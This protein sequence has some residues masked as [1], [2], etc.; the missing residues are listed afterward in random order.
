MNTKRNILPMLLVALLLFCLPM[1]SLAEDVPI[2]NVSIR[3]TPIKGQILLEKTG[4]MQTT[5]EQGYLK[6][7]VFEIRAA[8]DIIGQDGTPWYS[9]GELVATMTTSGEGVEKSPLLP[10]GKYTVK[11]VS[12]PSGYVLDLTTYTVE[13]QASDQETPIV[14]ATVSS[15]NHPAEILLQKTEADGKALS[16]AQ[17]VLL[18]ADGCETA[19]AVSDADGL[20]R[21]RF[22]PQGQYTI[23]ET[24]APDGY[25]LNRSA[26]SV[27]V[28]PNWTNAEEPIATMVNQQKKIQF[29]KV[30]TAGTPM[31]GILF[32]LINAETGAVAET[33][34]SD[35]NG[36]FAFT[37]FDYG[38]WT[39]HEAAAP[40]GYSRMADY[41]FQ[42]DDSWSGTAPVLL[43][44]IPDYYAFIKVDA[45]GKPLQGV[46]FAL[47]DADG[48]LLQTLES[49]EN[50]I[51]RAEHLQ[52]GTYYL[53]ETETLKGYTLSGDV[54]KLVIDEH[55]KIPEEMPQWVNYTTIQTGVQLAAS[56]GDAYRHC[57]DADKRHHAAD[58][59]TAKGVS[60]WC[61]IKSCFCAAWKSR[62]G[63]R[64]AFFM[65]EASM[66]EEIENKTLSLIINTSKFTERT[67]ATAFAKALKLGWNKAKE[68]HQA[69]PQGRQSVK[70]LIGQ[71]QG[72]EQTALADRQEV[73]A[74]ERYA[75][76]YGVDYAIHKGTSDSGKTRYLVFFKARDRAAIDQAMRAYAMDFLAKR[77]EQRN[78]QPQLDTASPSKQK[79]R[80]RQKGRER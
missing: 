5:G 79:E 48:N 40:S 23:C 64:A 42:V 30:D 78:V 17:F 80:S 28:T 34:V 15:I 10:L 8:E 70:Q 7:A 19:S 55:Y 9:C 36:A 27:T 14:S 75:R 18:D 12:A 6:G 2:Q 76:Q 29:I 46:K 1:A 50:G 71:N 49:D 66:Q 52:N 44:N 68:H 56:G 26:I 33:A 39:V 45:D 13:I 25:L 61:I 67:L 35:E 62:L 58:A 77:K 41:C 20:V 4:Q 57:P 51:V 59:Q 11:E 21:F 24:S 69:K 54:R 31:A 38:V 22:V 74:F 3:N 73:K 32:K 63:R 65:M 47:R 43:V 53:Q 60:E 72:V 16:G 37:A